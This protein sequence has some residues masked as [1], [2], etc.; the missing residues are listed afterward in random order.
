[1]QAS[2]WLP[3][4]TVTFEIVLL[5]SGPVKPVEMELMILGSRKKIIWVPNQTF[6]L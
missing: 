6:T 5:Q 1:M 2:W 3:T 4:I